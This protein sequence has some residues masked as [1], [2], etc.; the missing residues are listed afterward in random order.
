MS[1]HR[2]L[3]CSP[4]RLWTWPIAIVNLPWVPPYPCPCNP[5]P[6][7]L[8]GIWSE[9]PFS[10][11]QNHSCWVKQIGHFISHIAFFSFYF[12]SLYHQIQSTPY[13]LLFSQRCFSHESFY[14][15]WEWGENIQSSQL[16]WYII[17]YV[18]VLFNIVVT[19]SSFIL[20]SLFLS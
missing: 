13:P 8:R 19:V 7:S 16:Q 12:L 9:T 20:L 17:Q 10:Q 11:K 2:L 14:K 6:T 18:G 4:L 15:I 5:F 3:V 1:A